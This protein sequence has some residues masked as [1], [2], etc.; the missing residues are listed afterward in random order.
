LQKSL[1]S[2]FTGAD[3]PSTDRIDT[4]DT[5]TLHV[6]HVV[7]LEAV[8][9]SL[10]VGWPFVLAA[11]AC[12]SASEHQPKGVSSLASDNYDPDLAVSGDDDK[13]DDDDRWLNIKAFSAVCHALSNE[14][15]EGLLCHSAV[16]L[17][18]KAPLSNARAA[19]CSKHTYLIFPADNLSFADTLQPTLLV[20]RIA[21]LEEILPIVLPKI[22]SACH[23]SKGMVSHSD[24]R[25]VLH[26]VFVFACSLNAL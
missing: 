5:I 7:S 22:S 26:L 6:D 11:T 2:R 23:P 4:I 3:V 13:G 21:S 18:N 15:A 20:R 25:F 24:L 1:A 8:S 14:G 19:I 10:F 9:E 12:G 17:E 16:S